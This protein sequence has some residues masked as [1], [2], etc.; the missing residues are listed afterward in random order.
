MSELKHSYCKSYKHFIPLKLPVNINTNTFELNK[1]LRMSRAKARYYFELDI[2]S[3]FDPPFTN[4]LHTYID[5][6]DFGVN[7]YETYEGKSLLQSYI[8]QK[9]GLRKMRFYDFM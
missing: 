7:L 6:F 5:A 3:T 2:S 9:V 4:V 8:Q 1:P